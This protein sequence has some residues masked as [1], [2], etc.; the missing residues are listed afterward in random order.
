MYNNTTIKKHDLPC[1]N[2]SSNGTNRLSECIKHP[3]PLEYVDLSG[4]EPSPL[5]VYCAIIR[6]CCVNSLTLG[7][8]E[9]IKEYV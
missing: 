2:I 1:T 6:H 8:D 4:N 5:D 3:T 9:G 7:G